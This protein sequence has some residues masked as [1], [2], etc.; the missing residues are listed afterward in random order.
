MAKVRKLSEK[1]VEEKLAELSGWKLEK[2]K[3]HREFRFRD[4]IEAF[5]FMSR[6]AILAE[7]HDHHPEWYNVYNKVQIDYQTHDVGGISE[8]DFKLAAA[9]NK[10]VD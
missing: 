1:E 2:G 5:G 9:I 7:K 8:N 3:L 10:L 4:F 6:V